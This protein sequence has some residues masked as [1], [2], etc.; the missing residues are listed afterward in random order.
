[1][2]ASLR[3]ALTGASFTLPSQ[4]QFMSHRERIMAKRELYGRDRPTQRPFGL[5]ELFTTNQRRKMRLPHQGIAECMRRLA[6]AV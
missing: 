4:F 5:I 1:M 2:N 3:Q 6:R